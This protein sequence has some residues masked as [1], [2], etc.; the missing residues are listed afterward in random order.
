MKLLVVEDE[1]DLNNIITKYLK[2]NSYSVDS[3]YNGE[4]ALDFVSLS[5]YPFF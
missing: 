1:L 2:K 4:E 5:N 3:C